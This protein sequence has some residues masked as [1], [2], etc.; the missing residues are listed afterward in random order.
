VKWS[1]YKLA[2]LLF[3]AAVAVGVSVIVANFNRIVA[4]AVP[5]SVVRFESVEYGDY[6]LEFLG[7]DLVVKWPVLNGKPASEQ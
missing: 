2:A 3:I 5:V 6:R 7:E 4:P 1:K